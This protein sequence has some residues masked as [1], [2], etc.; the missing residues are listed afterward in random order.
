MGTQ[1][2]PA[3]Q[4]A[5]YESALGADEEPS[6]QWWRAG[7]GGREDWRT[8]A[9]ALPTIPS[10]VI[11]PGTLLETRSSGLTET[12]SRRMWNWKG[13]VKIEG[14]D[15]SLPPKRGHSTD[16]VRTEHALVEDVERNGDESRVGD[17][18]GADPCV[19]GQGASRAGSRLDRLRSVVSSGDLS[20]L[21]GLDLGHG[22]VVGFGVVLDGDL[23][24]HF[25]KE[26]GRSSQRA[27]RLQLAREVGRLTPSHGGDLPLV[28]SLD[29]EAD[30]GVHERHGHRDLRAVGQD[31]LLLHPRLLDVRE[32]LRGMD[33]QESG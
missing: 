27:G 33:G 17:P 6:Q 9:E 18:A 2:L 20:D 11:L 29:E 8:Y 30:V 10:M 5:Q 14:S 28:A 24:R 15:G 13:E 21:V 26:Q 19:S 12:S 25:E 31:V 3:I 32:D 4:L 7:E 23:G 16:L 1:P 22:R